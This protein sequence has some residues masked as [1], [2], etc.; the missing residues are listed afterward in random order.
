M[1]TSKPGNSGQ[2][3]L[4]G[5]WV[6]RF[7]SSSMIQPAF[8]WHI[9][10]WHTEGPWFSLHFKVPK[11]NM[12]DRKDCS[13]VRLRRVTVIL[14]RQYWFKSWGSFNLIFI[15]T[16]Y[17]LLICNIF[18]FCYY[19]TAATPRQSAENPDFGGNV[20]V[21]LLSTIWNFPFVV[22]NIYLEHLHITPTQESVAPLIVNTVFRTKKN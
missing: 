14:S 7:W 1:A 17:K 3:E 2:G 21:S 19:L 20:L 16:V 8:Y 10:A 13:L 9:P 12:I 4:P 11:G 5:F 6:G 18:K 15:A 22:L